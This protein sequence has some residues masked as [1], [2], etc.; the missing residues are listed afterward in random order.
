MNEAGRLEGVDLM[1]GIE[2]QPKSNLERERAATSFF[3]ND[4]SSMLLHQKEMWKGN[5]AVARYPLLK[6][7][8]RTCKSRSSVNVFTDFISKPFCHLSHL[9]FITYRLYFLVCCMSI[10]T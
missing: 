10:Q 2:V 7:W 8:G 3:S 4:R 1:L 5:A 6:M 9:S